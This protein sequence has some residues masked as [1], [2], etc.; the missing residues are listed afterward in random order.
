MYSTCALWCGANWPTATWAW[1]VFPQRAQRFSSPVTLVTTHLT[2][3]PLPSGFLPANFIK[4]QTPR[5]TLGNDS[6]NLQFSSRTCPPPTSQPCFVSFT[7]SPTS[8]CPHRLR[9]RLPCPACAHALLH[10]A[11]PHGFGIRRPIQRS[12][13]VRTRR[14]SRWKS[15]AILLRR[16]MAIHTTAREHGEN[17]VTCTFTRLPKLRLFWHIPLLTAKTQTPCRRCRWLQPLP[18]PPLLSSGP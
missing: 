3:S 10:L 1:R 4:E 6:V 12:L 15:S 14:A 2:S 8:P 7:P 13:P 16:P 11:P 9:F 5:P 17:K 18:P